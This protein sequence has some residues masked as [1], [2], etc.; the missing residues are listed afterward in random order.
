MF[1]E[2]NCSVANYFGKYWVRYCIVIL[3]KIFVAHKKERES[4]RDLKT[5]I[6]IARECLLQGWPT[7]DTR[8]QS[9]KKNK[10][11]IYVSTSDVQSCFHMQTKVTVGPERQ[12][13]LHPLPLRQRPELLHS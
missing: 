11:D 10:Q 7:Y 6:G 3:C 12:E 9:G 8:D 2:R 13:N 5:G 1:R 4:E